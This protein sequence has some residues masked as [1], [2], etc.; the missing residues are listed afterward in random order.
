[1]GHLLCGIRL[2]VNNFFLKRKF[3]KVGVLS[4]IS[5]GK[6]FNRENINIGNYCYIGPEAYWFGLGNINIG[7]GTI[8]GPCSKIWTANHNYKSEKMIP[9]DHDINL[10]PVN[11]G[12]GCWIGMNV[13]ISPGVTIGDCCIIAIGSV[14]TKNIPSYSIVSGNPGTIIKERDNIDKIKSLLLDEAFYLK[15]K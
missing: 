10:K 4:Q 8:I 1:M 14:V 6:F 2:K 13:S 3:N 7:D 11:I 5:T 15:N 12:K 9:Y